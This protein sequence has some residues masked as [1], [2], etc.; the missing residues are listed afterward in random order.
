MLPPLMPKPLKS[1]ARKGL[2]VPAR[3]VGQATAAG[4]PAKSALRVLGDPRPLRSLT[5]AR[6]ITPKA[7]P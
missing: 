5:V 4:K 1:R 2:P 3:G 7:S 6:T